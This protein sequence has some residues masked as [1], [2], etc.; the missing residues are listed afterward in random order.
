MQQN[1]IILLL[2]SSN[3]SP[4][5]SGGGGMFTP[6]KLTGIIDNLP[7][8]AWFDSPLCQADRNRLIHSCKVR[9][10]FRRYFLQKKIKKSSNE[11]IQFLQK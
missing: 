4:I 10:N 3:I 7:A 5:K 9:L 2:F 11:K 8:P 1:I 6:A